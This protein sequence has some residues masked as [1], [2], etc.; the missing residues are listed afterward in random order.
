MLRASVQTLAVPLTLAP[1]LFDT[2]VFDTLWQQL[3][4]CKLCLGV[5]TVDAINLYISRRCV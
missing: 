1:G 5:Q 2:V 3:T 4:V